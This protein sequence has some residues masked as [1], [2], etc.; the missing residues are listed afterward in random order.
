MMRKTNRANIKNREAAP[1]VSL[2]KGLEKASHAPTDQEIAGWV[3]KT[4]PVGE[5]LLMA[6]VLRHG[7]QLKEENELPPISHYLKEVE[8]DFLRSCFRD[9]DRSSLYRKLIENVIPGFDVGEDGRKARRSLLEEVSLADLEGQGKI[10]GLRGGKVEA[11][12]VIELVKKLIDYGEKEK[13]RWQATVAQEPK[14]EGLQIVSGP[15]SEDHLENATLLVEYL[16]EA[17]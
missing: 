1:K 4:P 2:V 14:Q 8:A 12:E 11:D 3:A 10:K 13:S 16:K 9:D 15:T 5:R 17:K 7:D 6:Y